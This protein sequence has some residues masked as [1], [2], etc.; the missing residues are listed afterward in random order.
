MSQNDISAENNQD[1]KALF[2]TDDLLSIIGVKNKE[3]YFLS[4]SNLNISGTF[5]F[6]PSHLIYFPTLYYFHKVINI[7]FSF[8]SDRRI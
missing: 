1:L 8:K 3:E 7:I 2:G 5:T 6:Y 4:P